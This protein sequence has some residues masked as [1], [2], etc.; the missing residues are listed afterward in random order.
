MESIPDGIEPELGRIHSGL[1]AEPCREVGRV[2]ESEIERHLLDAVGGAHQEVLG[3]LGSLSLMHIAKG[4][5][6][7]L[8]EQPVELAEAQPEVRRKA[9]AV[10]I[11]FPDVPAQKGQGPG[12]PGIAGVAGR[13]RASSLD[14]GLAPNQYPIHHGGL[15]FQV[16]GERHGSGEGAK[17]GAGSQ[18]RV[19]FSDQ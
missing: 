2:A 12:D 6:A 5:A 15:K 8:D 11:Q 16:G 1:L 19:G 3:V 9:I 13:W 18:E 14:Q 17:R 7:F 4:F 10:E